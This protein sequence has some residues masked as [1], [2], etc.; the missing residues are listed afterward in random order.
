GET[1]WRLAHADRAAVLIDGEEYFTALDDALERAQRSVR[2]LGWDL[3]GGIRLRR[4]DPDGR[5]EEAAPTLVERLDALVRRRRN[6]QIWLLEWDF[7]LLYALERQLL[8]ALRFGFSTHRRLHFRLDGEHPLGA[9][10]HQKIV[11]I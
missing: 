11:V 2:I 10:H 1:C 3:H 8:P 5:G 4:G 9:S 7:A 6:L